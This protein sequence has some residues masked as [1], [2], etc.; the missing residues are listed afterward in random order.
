MSTS[1]AT[2]EQVT[3]RWQAEGCGMVNPFRTS[4][5]GSDLDGAWP[6][7]V[8]PGF[9]LPAQEVILH[10]CA[11]RLYDDAESLL[12]PGQVVPQ[13]GRGSVTICERFRLHRET[14]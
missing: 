9:S 12:V 8:R 11:H 2:N 3:K 10:G 13:L 7:G 14:V 6:S 5:L 4:T 1:S